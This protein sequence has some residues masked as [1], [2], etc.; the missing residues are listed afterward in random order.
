MRCDNC[1]EK[2]LDTDVVCWH[3]GMP[4]A[5]REEHVPEKVTVKDSWQRGVSAS[6]LGLMVGMAVFVLIGALVMTFMLGRQPLVQVTFGTRPPS[7]WGVFTAAN[8]GFTVFLPTNWEWIDGSSTEQ[9]AALGSHLE[10]DELLYYG[11]Y[12]FGAEVDD[13]EIDFLALGPE[14]LAELPGPFFLVARSS[15][16]NQLGYNEALQFLS[17]GEYRADANIE[18][19]NTRYVDD[20]DKS[21]VATEVRIPVPDRRIEALS[22]QQQFVRGE[23][24]AMVVA[25]CSPSGRFAVYQG[26]FEDILASFQRLKPS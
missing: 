25:A 2:A 19:R 24:Q 13:L 1:G 14:P 12:P 21:H 26:N 5:G 20:F 22:C 9:S 6:S 17:S 8:M 18:V 3:C 15:V 10:N 11:T 7:G 23:G 4:L 16:L